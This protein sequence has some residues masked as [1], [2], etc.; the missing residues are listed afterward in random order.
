M[1]VAL[2]LASAAISIAAISVKRAERLPYLLALQAIIVGAYEAY[3]YSHVLTLPEA[4]VYLG[5]SIANSV[6]PPLLL[7]K[8]A[9]RVGSPPEG[10]P[11]A[12]VA[13]SLSVVALLAYLSLSP[14]SKARDV[15]LCALSAAV[16]IAIISYSLNPIRV[17]VALNMAS[18]ALHPLLGEGP[19]IFSAISNFF[20]LL[21]NGVAFLLVD[22][23]RKTYG[24]S[25]LAGWD[26]WL[27]K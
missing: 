23:A 10:A 19:P 15:A 4:V 6:L 16:P 26:E 5:A 22:H 1:E 14:P 12:A 24:E 9:G 25:N 3:S 27:R 8:L 21:V 7:L 20:M 17:I 11:R 2:P 13:F 18:N